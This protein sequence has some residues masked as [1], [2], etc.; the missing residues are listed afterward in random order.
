MQ[1]FFKVRRRVAEGSKTSFYTE[2]QK[3]SSVPRPRCAIG[4]L[5]Y[6]VGY[7]LVS[8]KPITKKSRRLIVAGR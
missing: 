4:I 6:I 5:T 7:P 2:S 8:L 3:N 1:V